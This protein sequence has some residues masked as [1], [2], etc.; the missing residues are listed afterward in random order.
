MNQPSQTTNL[1]VGT[2]AE[3]YWLVAHRERDVEPAQEGVNV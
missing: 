3:L 2:G 1:G